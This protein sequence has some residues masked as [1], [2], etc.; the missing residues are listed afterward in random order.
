[1]ILRKE[2]LLFRNNMPIR[3]LIFFIS[4]LK[5]QKKL[6]YQSNPIIYWDQN[7]HNNLSFFTFIQKKL[8][9]FLKNPLIENNTPIK[10]PIKLHL[11]IR[12]SVQYIISETHY[13]ISDQYF[14]PNSI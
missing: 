6:K 8:A 4:T 9:F 1:M 10:K 14:Y 3:K 7:L 11:T 2:T 13:I 12:L 5:R